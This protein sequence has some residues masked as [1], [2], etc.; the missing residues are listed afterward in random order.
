MAG[1]GAFGVLHV[2]RDDHGVGAIHKICQ[3]IE[4][5]RPQRGLFG[6]GI[7]RREQI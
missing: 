1:N 6:R 7:E 3:Q 4:K 2:D 5:L